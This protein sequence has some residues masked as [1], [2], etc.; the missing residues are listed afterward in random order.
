M[1][2]TRRELGLVLILG[3]ATTLLHIVTSEGYGIFRDEL[4]YLACGD[5]LR[6]GYVDHPPFVA[7]V[8]RFAR[9]L[10]GDSVPALRLFP[11]LCAGATVSLAMLLAREFGAG[12]WAQAL[13]ALLTALAPVYLSIFGYLSMNAVDFLL[14][15]AAIVVLAHLL[16][17][18][19]MKLWLVF[20]LVVGIGLQNKLSMGFLGVGVV[21][22]LLVT[23]R[24]EH[25]RTRW[26]WLGGGVALL[27]FLPYVVWQVRHGWP[28]LEFISRALQFKN[29]PLSPLEFAQEQ[30]LMMNPLALPVFLAG[31]TFLLV[32]P[33]GR[34]Y[35]P[36]GW[37]FVAVVVILMMQ[38]SKP[39]YLA[40]SYT[41]VFAA[42]SVVCA[43]LV[44]RL[45]K[46]WLRAATVGVITFLIVASGSAIAPL[47]KPLLPVE[48]FVAYMNR[49][50]MAPSTGENHELGRLPQF[51][52]DRLGWREL[53]ETVAQVYETLP[54]EDQARACI[55][56]Q[57]YG[58]AGAIDYFGRE[59]G[60]PKAMS[61]HNS[62]W[63]WGPG[64][65]TGEVVIVM[66]GGREGLESRFE[67][68]E[69][70]TVYT[71]ADCMPYENNKPI[72]ICRGMRLPIATLWPQ[73]RHY[74]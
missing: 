61:G 35:R 21:V 5:N 9:G 32:L 52:A 62:Y 33:S 44:S 18:G 31:I 38:N 2:D 64:D 29:A 58:Q 47:A 20:G 37:A 3:A 14:W 15:S 54:P 7:F 43:G 34:T 10:F 49:L 36:L 40:P 60:L 51:F 68:V 23:R 4:Y 8:A 42:G 28:T 1:Q 50:G 12:R 55:F 66:G 70:A 27:L 73:L 19:Q 67:S 41:L 22:G 30:L 6:L 13:T 74:D 57:N 71:C 63:S 25:F 39:Y 45:N 59:L 48:S 69:Q 11:A 26:L 72:W 65:C 56:G 16:R 53:A 24:W 46:P 17:T